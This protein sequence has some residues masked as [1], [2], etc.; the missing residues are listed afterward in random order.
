MCSFNAYVIS[1]YRTKLTW[2]ADKRGGRGVFFWI[3]RV[4]LRAYPTGAFRVPI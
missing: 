3:F 2:D 4:N 1:R